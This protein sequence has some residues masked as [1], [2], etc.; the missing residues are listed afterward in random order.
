MGSCSIL[1]HQVCAKRCS[2]HDL[3]DHVCAYIRKQLHL[4][5]VNVPC[6]YL[7]HHQLESLVSRCPRSSFNDVALRDCQLRRI[8]KPYKDAQNRL[9]W[10]DRTCSHVPSSHVIE[11]SLSWKVSL[12]FAIYYCDYI[13]MLTLVHTCTNRRRVTGHQSWY[14]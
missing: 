9:L 8:S 3:L 10:T 14:L 4:C 5:V 12:L 1:S 7:A 11:L 13:M 6:T 2:K